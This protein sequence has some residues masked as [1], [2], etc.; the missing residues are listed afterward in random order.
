ML[1]MV[2]D[3]SPLLAVRY[4]IIVIAAAFYSLALVEGGIAGWGNA[5]NCV[6]VCLKR[7]P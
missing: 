1:L 4:S 5:Q 7:F 6:R 2:R 3:T